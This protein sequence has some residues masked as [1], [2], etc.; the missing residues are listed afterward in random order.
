MVLRRSCAPVI[1][2]CL[3]LPIQSCGDAQTPT[4]PPLRGDIVLVSHGSLGLAVVNARE[5]RVMAR[6]EVIPKAKGFMTRSFDSAMLYLAA[7]TDQGAELIGLDTRSLVVRWTDTGISNGVRR[8]V[9]G[10][11]E[12]YGVEA[13]APSPDG[14]RLFVAAAYQGEASPDSLPGVVAIDLATHARVGF[15]GP[16]AIVGGGLA[17]LASGPA[18]PRGAVLAIGRRNAKLGPALDWLFMLDPATLTIRDSAAVGPAVARGPS[19]I[20]VLPSPDGRYAYLQGASQLYQYDLVTH[21]VLASTPRPSAGAMA[22][23]PDGSALYMTDQ[24]TAFDY[25]GSGK[26]FVYGSNLEPREPI[27]LRATAAAEGQ[28]PQTHFAAVSR[29]GRFLYVSAGTAEVGPLYT[30]Q[31]ARLLVVDV[32]HRTVI[33]SIPLAAWSPGPV[34]VR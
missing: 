34:F 19:I 3:A 9:G 21:Q 13:L 16:L 10:G 23:A 27:D 29:D 5:G 31:P 8:A 20:Q 11:I 12:I 33:Q 7:S 30:T 14:G 18:A 6:V 2:I 15:V 28:P 24:G 26:I 17:T 4:P 1:L 25:V 32:A 22:L